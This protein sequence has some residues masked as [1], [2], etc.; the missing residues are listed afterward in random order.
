MRRQPLRRVLVQVHLWLG[1]TIGLVWA[2]LGLS[3]AL[4]VFHREIDRLNM[5]TVSVGA[6]AP[7]D[8]IIRN[9]A[10]AAGSSIRTIG[11]ADGRGD[12]LTATYADKAGEPQALL[13]DAASGRVVGTKEVE[14]ATP[15]TGSA[16]R[17]LYRLHE[18]L[19]LGDAGETLVG[20]SGIVLL[21]AT[22]TGLAA[23]WPRRRQWRAA[24]AVSR[25]RS[26]TRKLYGWHRLTGLLAGFALLIIVPSGAYMIFAVQLRPAIARLVP[27][28]LPVR[29]PPGAVP[30]VDRVGAARALTEARSVFPNASFVRLTFPTMKS[31]AYV[32]RLHQPNETRVWSGTTSV[33]IA[34]NNGRVLG[35]YDPITAPFS[36][37]LADAAFSIHDGEL[38]G[39][40]G[41]TLAILVG[42]ALPALYV[43]GV[44][45]WIRKRQRENASAK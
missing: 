36:N 10:I 15:F 35:T 30:L 39:P 37:R 5:P 34:A 31:P 3:G 4:L 27:H 13:I 40:L 26:S 18:S 38:A 28:L 6:L 14:P 43:T 8:D 19:L 41:R 23:A 44:I 11:I 12:L 24:F 42:M 29:V 17:W 20:V 21:I 9:A 1:L 33:T 16:S 7:L 22:I 32:V 25:W 2:L 45:A